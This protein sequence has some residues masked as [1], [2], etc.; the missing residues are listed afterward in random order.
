MVEVA[1]Y[2]KWIAKAAASVSRYYYSSTRYFEVLIITYAIQE[3]NGVLLV[4]WEDRIDREKVGM[5]AQ[6]D[7]MPVCVRWA[8]GWHAACGIGCERII[9][10]TEQ[11]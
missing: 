8:S 9:R 2:P 1:N 10:R 4:L 3:M 5:D 7:E 11:P 6:T